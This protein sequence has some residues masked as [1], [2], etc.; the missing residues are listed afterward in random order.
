MK[1][2]ISLVLVLIMCLTLCACG[3]SQSVKDV[4]EAIKAIGE[5]SLESNDAILKAERLYDNLTDSEKS[6][7]DNK[8]MLVEAR[9]S[10][11][12]FYK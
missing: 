1:R 7:V 5:V 3:K 12:R 9:F 10:Y 2:V 8:A 11:D 6:K 4:E